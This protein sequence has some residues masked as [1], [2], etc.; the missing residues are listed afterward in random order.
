MATFSGF[1]DNVFGGITN[2]KGNLGDWQHAARTFV[3]DSFKF[4]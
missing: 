3:D 1:F 2:P 4:S